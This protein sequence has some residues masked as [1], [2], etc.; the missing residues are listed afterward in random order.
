[1]LRTV[2]MVTPGRLLDIQFDAQLTQI[3]DS[4]RSHAEKSPFLI[5]AQRLQSHPS[6][7]N[8]NATACVPASLLRN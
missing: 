4:R 8:H 7:E 2:V 1:M 5:V 6:N 3:A